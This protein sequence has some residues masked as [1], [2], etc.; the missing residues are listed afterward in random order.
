MAS[1]VLGNMALEY[2]GTGASAGSWANVPG[3]FSL[4]T[5]VSVPQDVDATDFDSPP[6]ESEYIG[7]PSQGDDFSFQCNFEP[8]NTVHLALQSLGRATAHL[9]IL[10]DD[11]AAPGTKV[12]A[13]TA[14]Q[15]ITFK[16]TNG[17]MA[18]QG[19]VAGKQSG[20]F[21]GRRTGAIAITAPS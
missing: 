18:V 10:I 3:V 8:T 19:E 2:G 14:A 16:V 5:P 17:R 4:T 12:T 21:T 15:I 13:L 7:G 11:Q 9:R 6:G 20:T 1:P